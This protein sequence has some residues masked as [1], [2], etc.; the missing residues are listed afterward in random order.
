[1]AT[2]Y[3]AIHHESYDASTV[4]GV[5]D[6]LVA[7]REHLEAEAAKPGAYSTASMATIE[8]WDGSERITTWERSFL[9]PL[10]WDQ[11]RY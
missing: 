3:L 11:S 8:V 4:F 2:H 10:I 5:F 6:D 9:S 1:M 7:A